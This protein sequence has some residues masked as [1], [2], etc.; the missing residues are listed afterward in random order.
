MVCERF[1]DPEFVSVPP[2]G[3]EVTTYPLMVDPPLNCGAVN[4]TTAELSPPV[5]VPII[6]ALDAAGLSKESSASESLHTRAMICLA[7]LFS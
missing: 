6:G 3:L 2:A 4:V 1:V 5:A 7:A